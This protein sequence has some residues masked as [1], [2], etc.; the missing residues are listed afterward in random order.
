MKINEI[1][2]KIRNNEDFSEI[3]R[4][5][6]KDILNGNFLTKDFIRRQYGLL[7]LLVV[8][9]FAY[10]DN[11]FYCEKQQARI[12]ALQKQLKETKYEALTI[13]AELMEMSRQSNVQKLL[14]QH[15]INIEESTEPAIIIK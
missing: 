4:G 11:R 14:K 6:I 10:I 13:S 7:L 12:V 9:A 8:L 15:N 5:S 2:N 1:W 3:K